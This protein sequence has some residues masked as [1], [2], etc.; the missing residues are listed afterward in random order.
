MYRLF[1]LLLFNVPVVVKKKKIVFST[2]A[3]YV[4]PVATW[5]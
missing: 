2:L 3:D 1:L 4:L 5:T